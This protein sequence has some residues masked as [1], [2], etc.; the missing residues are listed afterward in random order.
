VQ[1]LPNLKGYIDKGKKYVTVEVGGKSW[2][3]KLVRYSSDRI[4]M[5]LG[6]RTFAGENGLEGGDV[7]IFELI[8]RND[9]VFK[10]HI[11]KRQS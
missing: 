2:S 5:G 1:N 8:S 4:R 7:C 9:H 6:W 11:F 10:V 3:L